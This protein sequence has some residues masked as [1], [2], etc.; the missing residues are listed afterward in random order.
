MSV[1][2]VEKEFAWACY[3]KFSMLPEGCDITGVARSWGALKEALRQ[4]FGGSMNFVDNM[5]DRYKI[6]LNDFRKENG[7]VFNQALNNAFSEYIPILDKI[8]KEKAESEQRK[9]SNPFKIKTSYSIPDD[10]ELVDCNKSIVKMYLPNDY[11]GKGTEYPFLK[12]LDSKYEK[13]DWWFK[14]GVG[15]EYLGFKYLNLSDNK[16]RG[17][18]PDWIIKFKDNRIGIFDTKQGITVSA[19]DTKYKTEELQRRIKDLNTKSRFKYIGGIVRP[20]PEGG[21][22]YNNSD[23]YN[24]NNDA[25]WKDMNEIF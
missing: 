13:I 1:N 6:F 24:P 2:D 15:K 25:D 22:E 3:D 8:R 10:Y 19:P 7:S 14:N 18:Y 11:A 5:H 23:V 9:R 21:W 17:F 20:K 16:E 12:Y 4:W